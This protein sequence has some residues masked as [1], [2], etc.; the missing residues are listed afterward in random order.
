M[1]VRKRR[2]AMIAGA[3]L[4]VA[5]LAAVFGTQQKA[6]SVRQPVESASVAS[7]SA[8]QAGKDTSTTAS[9]DAAP[10]SSTTAAGGSTAVASGEVIEI[11]EKL[12]VAQTNDVYNNTGDYL[13]KTLKYEGIFSVYQSPE[14]GTKYYSVIRYGP[15]CC[16][17]D[18]NCG[19]EVIW[20]DGQTNY[21]DQDDWV[22][23]TG[24]LEEYQEDGYTFLR[25]ALT[26]LEPLAVRGEE[27]VA[28]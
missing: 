16:G 7:T 9:T 13:G 3:V 1:K 15:G 27:Y 2:I 10:S 28:Q 6:S 14:T 5:L 22:E 18:A 11:K 19:F 12:F 23:A 26:S 17:I 20:P 4:C 24:V 25:L 8:T 21:P